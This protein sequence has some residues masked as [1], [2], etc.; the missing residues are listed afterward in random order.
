MAQ[1]KFRC[2]AELNDFLPSS[3]RQ[4][5]IPVEFEPPAPVRH[6][7]ETLG[8]PHTEVELVLVNG[9]SVDL[10]RRIEEG[11]RVSLYPMFEA[12]DVT[13]ALRLRPEPLRE[14]RFVV[15]AHLGKLA[16]YLR[17]L[18]FDT[19]FENDCGDAALVRAVEAEHRIL[20]TRDRALLMRRGVTHGCY[21]RAVRPLEQLGYLIRRLDLYRCFRPFTRCML[22]NGP[23]VGVAKQEVEEAIPP[24]VRAV[25]E[26]FWRCEGCGQVYWRG[27][28]Y[29]RLHRL[30]REL[31]THSAP[32]RP[33][34]C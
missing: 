9:E 17:L 8:V 1:A 2:Y 23:L 30:V 18:G 28:H 34:T 6:L 24:R 32:E 27:S 33:E 31:G 22:C 5:D 20:L 12:L 19:L 16:R 3:Q 14:P 10:E 11:D 13:P 25:Q 29:E 15:D 7:M 21:I 4:R 26:K